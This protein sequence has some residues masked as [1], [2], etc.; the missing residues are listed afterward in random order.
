[1]VRIKVKLEG[2]FERPTLHKTVSRVSKVSRVSRVSRVVSLK[3]VSR[4]CYSDLFLPGLHVVHAVLFLIG[5]VG[6]KH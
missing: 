6:L 2:C 5:L 4:V 3:R 1:M